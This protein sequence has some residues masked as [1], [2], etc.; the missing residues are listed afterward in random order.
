MTDTLT[1]PAH[2]IRWGGLARR[3]T[4]VVGIRLAA[5]RG[6]SRS[7]RY[8]AGGGL[9][10]QP[11]SMQPVHEA[12]PTPTKFGL[13]PF[14]RGGHSRG[15]RR[16]RL[17]K[18]YFRTRLLSDRQAEQIGPGIAEVLLR[19][20]KARRPP[21]LLGRGRAAVRGYGRGLP[22]RGIRSSTATLPVPRR[23]G[24]ARDVAQGAALPS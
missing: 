18:G 21:A 24:R 13:D 17:A 22:T 16:Q 3:S 4:A 23:G 19:R 9:E 8:E 2:L 11:F 5:C 20:H 14:T 15:A 12:S 6:G 10:H 7:R 1:I